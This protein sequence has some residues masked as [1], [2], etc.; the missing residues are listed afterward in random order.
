[1]LVL[2]RAQPQTLPHQVSSCSLLSLSLEQ[3][4]WPE[5]GVCTPCNALLA[6]SCLI[7]RQELTQR[8]TI[9]STN[10]KCKL[11]ARLIRLQHLRQATG[12]LM[13]TSHSTQ[14]AS[15]ASCLMQ[16]CW[17]S[18]LCHPF[19]ASA[20]RGH[21]LQASHC[22][23]FMAY[24]HLQAAAGLP[25]WQRGTSHGQGSICRPCGQAH[26]HQAC[27][28][29]ATAWPFRPHLHVQ[30]TTPHRRRS[31]CPRSS[32]PRSSFLL[33]PHARQP[34]LLMLHRL[35]CKELAPALPQPR[36]L[37]LPAPQAISALPLP[38]PQPQPHALLPR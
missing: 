33:L 15:L 20:I 21:H 2:T 24:L 18:L 3:Q 5:K 11:W 29:S 23:A 38:W 17:C 16:R 4:E 31:P 7:T 8:V 9:R 22:L 32:Q 6:C 27:N 19:A 1:M 36:P 35:W 10:K 34:Q 37:L 28:G 25:F 13:V 30:A 26:Q 12:L 14:V